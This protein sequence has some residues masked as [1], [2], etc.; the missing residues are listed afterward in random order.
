MFSFLF[1][2]HTL[3]IAAHDI[4]GALIIAAP[5]DFRPGCFIEVFNFWW[6]PAAARATEFWGEVF[7]HLLFPQ[8]SF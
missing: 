2:L 3:T 5:V 7:R 4:D 8:H 6:L 1:Y